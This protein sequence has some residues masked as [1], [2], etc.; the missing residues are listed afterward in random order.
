MEGGPAGSDLS[1]FD[2]FFLDNLK[3]ILGRNYKLSQEIDLTTAVTEL[4]IDE[5]KKCQT[6]LKL[7]IQMI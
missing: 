7:T 2:I 4:L 3:V 5:R 1:F 6:I